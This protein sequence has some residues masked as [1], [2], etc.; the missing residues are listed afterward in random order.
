MKGFGK[1]FIILALLLPLL[2]G[3]P[4]QAAH[5]VNLKTV[6]VTG[7]QPGPGLWKVSRG[8]HVLW[9]LGTLEELPASIEW[10]AHEVRQDIAQSRQVLGPPTVRIHAEINY[11]S[12][13]SF[14]P[15]GKQLHDILPAAD[16]AKWQRLKALYIKDDDHIDS[17]RPIF[18][19][20]KLY[21]AALDQA[22]LSGEVIGPV[23]REAMQQGHAKW[24]PVIYHAQVKDPADPIRNFDLTQVA[25]LHCFEQTLNH[26]QGDIE[27]MRA[28]ANAWAYGDLDQLSQLPMSDQLDVCRAAIAESGAARELSVDE[29][30]TA[31]QGVWVAAASQALDTNPVSF[32]LLPMGDLLG[33]GNYLAPLQA[34]GDR[35]E[36]PDGLTPPE[37]MPPA[38]ASSARQ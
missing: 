7:V 11:Y 15:A 13:L 32:A 3:S 38:S 25:D 17:H 20:I 18:A 27:L 1:A 19:A 29:L 34:Q 30:R 8:D 24:T 14:N 4:V 33:P 6:T 22:D 2:F 23:I 9:V 26:L 31:M 16:Y 5:V 10:Q 37:Q 28:R 36:L 12:K 35:V 21:L